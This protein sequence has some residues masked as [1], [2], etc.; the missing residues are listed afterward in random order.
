M[1]IR[2]GVGGLAK[3]LETCY[4]FLNS[5]LRPTTAV[6]TTTTTHLPGEHSISPTYF[7]DSRSAFSW[8]FLAAPSVLFLGVNSTT[9]L[10]EDVS[11][12]LK[13]EDEISSETISGLR[14]IEDGSVVS[15]IHTSKWRV[16]TDTGRDRFMQGKMEDAERLFQ[17]AI[18]EAKEGFGERDP[19]VASACNNL[20]ELYRVQKVFDKAEPLYLEAVKVLEESLGLEDIRVGAA[21][22][23]LGQFYLVQQKLDKACVSYER[24]LKIKRRVLGEGHTDYADTMYHLGTVL[25]LLGKGK[26]SEALIQDSIRI[27]EDNG[28]GESVICIRRLRYLAQI[29]IKSSRAEA[30]MNIQR[31]ILQ[32]MELTKGWNSLETVIAA[33]GLALTL[34]SVGSSREAQELFERCLHARKMLLSKDHI[35]IAGNLLHIARVVM[36]N[37]S[38][39]KKTCSSEAITEFNKAKDLLHESV[40]CNHITPSEHWKSLR[41]GYLDMNGTMDWFLLLRNLLISASLRSRSMEPGENC[42]T[43]VKR[44]QNIFPV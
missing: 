33:E 44:R 9:V 41:W 30:A 6:T 29:Y 35:Q 13:S 37:S 16:F 36:H 43:L 12:G 10:A 42:P 27:L 14:K 22:H 3:R 8:I 23:N 40:S 32:K 4:P 31:K 17:A 15:N 21:L 20:A 2:R 5:Y 7:D 19:H 25:H 24:A 26:D 28:Q 34:Q 11:V 1:S 18:Q 39:L 38:Q